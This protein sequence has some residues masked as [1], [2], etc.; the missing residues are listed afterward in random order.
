MEMIPT[1]LN[2]RISY[3]GSWAPYQASGDNYP[4]YKA[5]LERNDETKNYIK[6]WDNIFSIISIRY[7]G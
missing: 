3:L 4:I 6:F 7:S 5:W 1:L 2:W